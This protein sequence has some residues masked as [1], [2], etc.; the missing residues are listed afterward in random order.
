MTSETP[1][2]P[3]KHKGYVFLIKGTQ[4]FFFFPP[5]KV[6][7]FRAEGWKTIKDYEK[8]AAKRLRK[9]LL[10]VVSDPVDTPASA[11]IE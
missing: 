8:L 10:P 9:N 7:S 6:R 4:G 1:Y 2:D 11:V 5:S 3:E